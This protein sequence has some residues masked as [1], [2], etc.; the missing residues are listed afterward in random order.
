MRR[1]GFL[2]SVG[3]T[4]FTGCLRLQ[5]RAPSPDKTVSETDEPSTHQNS[6]RQAIDG[7]WPM[8]GR[9]ATNT[10]HLPNSPG[11]INSMKKNWSMAMDHRVR[12]SPTVVNNT[13]FIGDRSGVL[14]AVRTS[15]GTVRWSTSLDSAI[16]SSPVISGGIVFVGTG[17]DS[18]SSNAQAK[19]FNATNGAQLWSKNVDSSAL[20]TPVVKD[21]IVYFNELFGKLH[22]ID[23]HQG[24]DLWEARWPL[25]NTTDR[26]V[27]RFNIRK[28][29][30]Q[31]GLTVLDSLIVAPLDS[32]MGAFDIEEQKMRWGF[33][34]RPLATPAVK[35]NYIYVADFNGYLYSINMG[36]GEKQWAK[37]FSGEMQSSPAISKGNIYFGTNAGKVHALGTGGD[38]K[39]TFKAQ[40]AVT[41]SPAVTETTVYIG[42]DA[43]YMY[44]LRTN[45]GSK[46][47]AF[48]ADDS[49][50]SSPTVAGNQ[51]FFGS[52]DNRLYALSERR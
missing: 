38:H 5:E 47:W 22:A 40:G 17:W 43:G 30:Y 26:I 44:A 48:R 8:F 33:N 15:S 50:R 28:A 16:H 49:I 24:T 41:T 18:T 14:L 2:A 6:Q 20:L 4:S 7:F 3:T 35:N 10:S 13:V 42:D 29:G 52:D 45:D 21:G 9:S 46:R 23:S 32:Y 12:S 19:A 27:S 34:S 25:I 11:P 37:K 51:L 31:M 1:R 36:G 39:W